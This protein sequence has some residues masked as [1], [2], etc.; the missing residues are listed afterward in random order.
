M[1][2]LFY[3][4]TILIVISCKKDVIESPDC[5]RL[6]TGL[7]ELNESIVKQEIEKLTADLHPQP[8]AEDPTGHMY[9]LQILVDRLNNDCSEFIASVSCY[10][11]IETYPPMSEV[12]VE[13]EEA[14]ETRK[15]IIDLV[16]SGEDILRFGG[17]HVQ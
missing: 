7:L 4:A 15:V 9:N 3:I 11:C 14:G 12:L 2:K 13:F 16:T 5:K 8:Q 10:A 6:R 1:N 17:I